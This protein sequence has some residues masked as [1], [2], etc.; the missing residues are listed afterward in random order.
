MP[1]LVESETSVTTKRIKEITN[2]AFERSYFDEGGSVELVR[3]L[4][5]LIR[6]ETN[7]GVQDMSVHYEN[8]KV[9]LAGYCRTF[10][11]KQL[12]QQAAMSVL[13]GAELVNNIRVV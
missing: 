9:I 7:L 1:V 6:R 3:R 5:R 11:T 2:T 8:G 12:A 10:Y 4:S 13:G